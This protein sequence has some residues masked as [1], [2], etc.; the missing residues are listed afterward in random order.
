ME[1]RET[2]LSVKNLKMHFVYDKTLLGKPVS[3]VKAVDGVSFD[4][5]D[6]ETF[7]LVGE[8]GC[9][10]TT[11]GKCV[12]RLYSPTDGEIIYKGKHLE[13]AGATELKPVRREIQMVFQDPYGSLDPRQSVFSILKEAIIRDRKHHSGKEIASRVKELLETVGLNADFA[14]RYPHELSGGQRQRVGIARALACNPKLIVC[15]EPVSALDVS[16]QA[17]IINLFEEM[18]D[19]LNLTYLFVAHDLAVVQHVADRIGIMYLG[20]LVEVID[21]SVLEKETLHPYT[22]ALLSA[23]P[24][25]DYEAEQKREQILLEGEVPSPLNAPTGCPFNPRCR[26]ATERCRTEMPALKEIAANHQIACHRADEFA[27]TAREILTQNGIAG[28]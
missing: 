21:A 26:F 24:S 18:Q 12:L 15:D 22:I 10:K 19:K 5:H 7:G 25:P 6:G 13:K 27:G 23:I 16:I 11:V 17:E 28:D 20:H 3:V 9:G 14:S 2:L 1:K 8:S 4:I